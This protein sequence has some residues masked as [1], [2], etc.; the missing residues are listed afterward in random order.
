M[1]RKLSKNTGSLKK[2]LGAAAVLASFGAVMYL[3]NRLMP[4]YADDY[5]YSFIWEGEEHGNLCMG[6]HQYRRVRNVPDLLKSQISHYKTWDGRTIAES[7]VQLFL[8]PDRK[9]TFDAANTAVML[10]QLLICAQLG[11]SSRKPG[12]PAAGKAALLAAGFW[13]CT[14]HLAGS[15]FWLTGSM[16]YLWVGVLQSVYVLQYSRRFKDPSYKIPTGIAALLGLLAGW[17]TETGAGA[18]MMLSSMGL[19]YSMIR[20]ESDAW[21][22]AGVLGCMAGMLLLLLSPGNRIKMDLER[23]YSDT[24]PADMEDRAPGYVPDEYLYTPVMFKAYFMEGFLPT[25]LRLLPLQ[26]P[27][28]AYYFNRQCRTGEG[29][30]YIA[31]LEA[32]GLAVPTVM[33]LSPEYPLRSTYPSVIYMLGAALYALNET[34]TEV[35]PYNTAWFRKCMTGAAVYLVINIISSLIVDGDYYCQMEDQIAMLKSEGRDREAVL[36]LVDPPPVYSFLAGN[37]S[38]DIYNSMGLGGEMTE[39]P[40]NEATAAYFGTGSYRVD[41]ESDHPYFEKGFKGMVFQLT[42][43]LKHFAR[44]IKDLLRG[45]DSGFDPVK[46]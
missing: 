1:I 6:N 14:P 18:A 13:T 15:V 7:L 10:S 38:I 44:R 33:M 43:P 39:D 23:D 26:I 37:R 12:I 5:P 2:S 30:M 36:P 46:S 41:Y 11:R 28:L 4:K 45:V 19:L 9:K 34:G 32:A 40:Y 27:V 22:K 16:N 42:Q 21:M 24:L 20:R 29:D 17:S 35:Y 25:V 31:A 8:M 3:K